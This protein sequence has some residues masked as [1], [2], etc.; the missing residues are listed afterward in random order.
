MSKKI[1]VVMTVL[2]A[3]ACSV[4]SFGQTKA[5]FVSQDGGFTIDLPREGYQGVEPI[6]DV[7]SGSGTYAWVTDDGQ[8]SVS[9]LEGAFSIQSAER[10][11][12]SL[13]DL[14]ISSPANRQS[15]ILS[16]RKLVADGNTIIELR[17]KR[18]TGSA[19]NRLVM[20]KRRLYVITADWLEGSGLNSER[21]LDSFE[22]VDGR[23]LIA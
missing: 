21:V 6:G 2:L 16:R 3:V 15:T 10:S 12:D 19:I 17:I 18:P 20:V 11:L 1:C 8:F 14:I 9:Y 23:S 13:A 4:S 7:N 22:L 5:K